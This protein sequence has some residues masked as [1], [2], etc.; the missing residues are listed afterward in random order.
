[1]A[2]DALWV[3]F[4]IKLNKPLGNDIQKRTILN[5]KGGNLQ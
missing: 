3:T 1:M 2:D 4:K 5:Q